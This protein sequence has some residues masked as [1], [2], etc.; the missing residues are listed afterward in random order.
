MFSPR[1]VD[2]TATQEAGSGR[3]DIILASFVL[4][5][6]VV[7]KLLEVAAIK[8]NRPQLVIRIVTGTRNRR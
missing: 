8:R 3:F 5:A 7:T 4:L 2:A 1:Y 6:R